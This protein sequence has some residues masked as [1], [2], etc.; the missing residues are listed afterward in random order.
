MVVS[1]K[2]GSKSDVFLLDGRRWLSS[3][4]LPSDVIVE[5][6]EISFRLHKFPLVSRSAMM[7]KLLD[8]TQT[9]KDGKHSIL[10]LHE[11]P[12]GAKTL[13]L[14]AKFCYGVKI[15]LNPLNVASLRCAAEFLEMT[16]DYGEG[17]L[18]I[19]TE[20]VLDEVFGSWED[21][22][23]TLE[24][25]EEV[26][27]W[28]EE[29]HIVNR[30]INSMAMK[31]CG[32]DGSIVSWPMSG[33]ISTT[34]SSSTVLWN[35]IQTAL[36]PHIAATDDW[37]YHDA[38]FLK[39]PFYKR[40][41]RAIE[42]KGTK[43]E[44]IAGSVIHY[45]KKYLPMTGR[46]S[47]INSANHSG[48]LSIASSPSCVNVDQRNLLEEV[49]ELLPDQKGVAP[50]KFL[51]RLLKTSIILHCT[52]SCQENLEKRA[53][54]QL[55]QASVED[56]LIPNTVYSAETLYDTDRVQGILDH[57]LL[58]EKDTNDYASSVLGYEGHLAM[59][60]SSSLTPMTMVAKLMD[61][62]LAEVAPD[63]NLKLS[64][65]Q[66]LASAIPEYA[67]PLDDG[68]YQAIDIYLKAHPWLT[69]SEKEQVCRL[70]N[71]QKLSLEAST[72]AAQNQRLPL[73][74]IVQV[75]FFEQ[76]RLRTSIAGCFFV[77]DNLEN[78]TKSLEK[79]NP[80]AHESHT[81]G[82]SAQFRPTQEPI[83]VMDDM[84]ERISE[85]EMECMNM[86]QELQK[87]VK[88]KRSWNLLLKRLG[89]R[90]KSL[91]MDQRKLKPPTKAAAIAAEPPLTPPL[92]SEKCFEGEFTKLLDYESIE[93]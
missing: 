86:K 10:N 28:A 35:G 45:A 54:A 19:Q 9:Q 92:D 70:M 68:I 58:L 37:W 48:C 22:L 1:V 44:V 36:G 64:K 91:S 26:L 24:S 57:F 3:T 12:G 13:L 32:G 38:S 80:S 61:N 81:M 49:V 50:T 77:S 41:I 31:L 84:K 63:V 53:G 52:P 87:F 11:I 6:G 56:L 21:S 74:V 40:L 39:L 42:S 46:Q 82:C 43:A 85:L 71:C 93:Q 55:D 89:L 79:A 34:T 33:Q 65:F 2:L 83:V 17:N 8:E 67:R 25:C 5:V 7:E 27:S 78:N 14:V 90:L 30:C 18:I 4:G 76:L 60:G 66:A 69:D 15:E 23:K 75:L 88:S 20:N 73:R 72:H 51:L 59:G 29:L 62:Y 16:E 47:G